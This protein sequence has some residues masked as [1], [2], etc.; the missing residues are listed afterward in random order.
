MILYAVP[1]HARCAI[2]WIWFTISWFLSSSK[3]G[4]SGNQMFEYARVLIHSKRLGLRPF[5]SQRMKDNLSKFFRWGGKWPK[6]W[7]QGWYVRSLTRGLPFMTSSKRVDVPHYNN[8]LLC[9]PWSWKKAPYFL[10]QSHWTTDGSRSW[11]S[12][13]RIQLL[14]VSIL[15]G[16]EDGR[17]DQLLKPVSTTFNQPNIADLVWNTFQSCFY[18]C[19]VRFITDTL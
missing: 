13:Q 15:K 3:R 12:E 19:P 16:R 18:G 7:S 17:Y 10:F 9:G 6:C 4:R 1:F 8:D 2:V 14:H 5:I 11:P